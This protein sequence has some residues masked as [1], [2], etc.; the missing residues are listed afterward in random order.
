MPLAETS[1]GA[2]QRTANLLVSPSC[3]HSVRTIQVAGNTSSDSVLRTPFFSGDDG[4]W[5][6]PSLAL[7]SH[8]NGTLRNDRLRETRRAMVGV[9]SYIE[10]LTG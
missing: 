5:S 7:L 3:R 6:S 2:N 8:V 4:A 1:R 9:A 10:A